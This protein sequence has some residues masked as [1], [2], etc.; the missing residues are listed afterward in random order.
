MVLVPATM[1]RIQQCADPQSRASW[2]SWWPRSCVL[3]PEPCT[4]MKPC[5]DLLHLPAPLLQVVAMI[6]ELLETRIRPAVQEDGG[7]IVYK[8]FDPDSGTVVLQMQVRGWAGVGWGG[9]RYVWQRRPGQ[10]FSCSCMCGFG[11][12][13]D[14]SACQAQAACLAK[15]GVSATADTQMLLPALL[16]PWLHRFQA[17]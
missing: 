7:D 5:A 11:C 10:E 2:C 14:S 1:K 8:S 15:A 3:S 6:K 16:E 13:R 17:W 4:H 12:G 9:V